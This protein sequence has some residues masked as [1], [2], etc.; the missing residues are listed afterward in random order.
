[1]PSGAALLADPAPTYQPSPVQ[2]RGA[3]GVAPMLGV[4]AVAAGATPKEEGPAL[5][6]ITLQRRTLQ[7]GGCGLVYC[8]DET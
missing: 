1:M 8:D 4:T 3:G 5:L 2:Q 7:V 6:E